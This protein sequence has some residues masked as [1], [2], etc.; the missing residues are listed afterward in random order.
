MNQSL[1]NLVSW[2]FLS[3]GNLLT[4][5]CLLIN[6]EIEFIVNS[7]LSHD[8][9]K[10]IYHCVLSVRHISAFLYLGTLGRL[11][12]PH[13]VVI[14][15]SEITNKNQ[16]NEK[17][18]IGHKEDTLQYQ[19]QNQKA[20]ALLPQLGIWVA[21]TQNCHSLTHECKGLWKHHKYLFWNCKQVVANQRNSQIHN[22][23]LMRIGYILPFNFL[24]LIS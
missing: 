23:Q 2:V 24:L 13:S 22:P 6:T 14:F 10:P 1:Y 9:T 4:I 5:Y 3:K 8:R 20:D 7:T 18:E 12:V 11:S 17:N 16:K 19:S 21:G 15:S